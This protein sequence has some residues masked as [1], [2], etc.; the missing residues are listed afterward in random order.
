MKRKRVMGLFLVLLLSLT[1]TSSVYAG[2]MTTKAWTITTD[3]AY[4]NITLDDLGKGELANMT[5]EIDEDGRTYKAI[6][7]TASVIS[8]SEPVTV[9]KT[10]T[11]L[12][13]KKVQ[14]SITK[15]G[16]KLKLDDVE[17]TE[18]RRNAATG[19]LT[20]KGSDKRPDAPK[21]KESGQSIAAML[22][23]VH[24][25]IREVI[26]DRMLPRQKKLRHL[27]RMEAKYPLLESYRI[28]SRP[29]AVI[30]SHSQ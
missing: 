15:S 4:A 23:Q 17:W 10:Y 25:P 13:D 1:S 27:Y 8:K 29:A 6:K 19:T 11:N 5:A 16:E 3:Q 2:S 18:H 26:K 21:T 22:Q 20:Y 30:A 24:L 9:K 28:S 14:K 12:T 7:V